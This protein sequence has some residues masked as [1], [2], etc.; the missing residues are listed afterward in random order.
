MTEVLAASTA[1]FAVVPVD[2]LLGQFIS[3]YLR[4]C[5]YLGAKGFELEGEVGAE[6]C[7]GSQGPKIRLR[8][9]RDLN[10]QY[11]SFSHLALSFYFS[12]S[13]IYLFFILS[14]SFVIFLPFLS[15]FPFRLFLSY[16][17]LTSSNLFPSSFFMR[18][19]L[20]VLGGRG[21][22]REEEKWKKKSPN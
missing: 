18:G 7:A 10:R 6:V 9:K 1:Q 19:A 14:L 17:F 3:H 22:R 12:P 16:S 8:E 15:E 4:Q 2:I 5:G 13:S 21:C 11:L 20:S